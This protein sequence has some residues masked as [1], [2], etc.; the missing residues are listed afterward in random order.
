MI[1]NDID[2]ANIPAHMAVARARN[3]NLTFEV[4]GV[5]Y[6]CS[7]TTARERVR[8]FLLA[9]EE[10]LDEKGRIAAVEARL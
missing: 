3:P 5:L 9:E 10:S 4:M 1:E 7:A 6:E 8:R 2:P